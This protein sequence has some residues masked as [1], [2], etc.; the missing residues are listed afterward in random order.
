MAVEKHDF[1]WARTYNIDKAANWETQ[2]F[3]CSSIRRKA[4]YSAVPRLLDMIDI[5]IFDF[6]AGA[7]EQ[8]IVYA[9]G[10]RCK[11]ILINQTCIFTI[12]LNKI[13]LNMLKQ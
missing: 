8:L 2:R 12:A 1:P 4:P 10:I 5:A 13:R 6:L 11:I 9:F 3:Y 7:L